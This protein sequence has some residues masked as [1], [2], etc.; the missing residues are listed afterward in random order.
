MF[1]RNGCR[2]CAS[3]TKKWEE[4]HNPKSKLYGMKLERSKKKGEEHVITDSCVH[5]KREGER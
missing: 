5:G 2:F 4:C 1:C 3:I